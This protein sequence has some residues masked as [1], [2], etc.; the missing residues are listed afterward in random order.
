MSEKV[1][2]PVEKRLSDIIYIFFDGDLN[3]LT[4]EK[5]KR[6]YNDPKINV[7]FENITENDYSLLKG[8]ISSMKKK[9]NV[10]RVL[11]DKPELPTIDEVIS[12]ESSDDKDLVKIEFKDFK[13]EKYVSF[14]RKAFI[15]FIN[16][17]FYVKVKKLSEKNDFKIYQNFVKYYLSIESPYRGLLVYHGLGTGKTA[18]AVTTAESLS[19]N[20]NIFTL[21]PTS[22]ETNFINEVKRWR[23]DI[24]DLENNNWVFMTKLEVIDDTNFR[25]FL[26]EKYNITVED[27]HTIYLQTKRKTDDKIEEGFW[28]VSDDIENDKDKIKTFDGKINIVNKNIQSE[29]INNKSYTKYNKDFKSEPIPKNKIRIRC[30]NVK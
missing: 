24:F 27:L 11:Q 16:D 19:E 23:S 22:L 14:Q 3:G 25:K 28:K 21:L 9:P 15:D 20:M 7:N 13:G 2:K 10:K 1:V 26:V 6:V 4:K 29:P 30:Y 18:T 5:L 17:D 12:K 8:L